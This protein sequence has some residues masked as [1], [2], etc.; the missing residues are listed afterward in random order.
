[1]NRYIKGRNPII[2]HLLTDRFYKA[3]GNF[4]EKLDRE[5]GEFYGGNFLGIRQRLEES[6]FTDLG[7]DAIWISAPYQQIMGWVPGNNGISR[8]YAYHGYWPLDFT[9][10]EPRFGTEDE[11]HQMVKAAHKIGIKV[12][13]DI[14]VGHCGYPDVESF[15]KYLPDAI[16]SELQAEQN[17]QIRSNNKFL[18]PCSEILAKWW[19]P[20]WIRS[21]LTGHIPGGEDDMTVCYHGLPR[22][23]LDNHQSVHLPHFLISKT[24][25]R[26][27]HLPDTNVLGYLVNWLTRWV[28]EHGID[29]FRCDSAK[30]VPLSVWTELR[31][32]ASCALKTWRS[33]QKDD[34]NISPFWMLG[35]VYGYGPNRKAQQTQVF[36]SLINFDFQAHVEEILTVFHKN[37]SYLRSLA[38]LRLDE[39]YMQYAKFCDSS[40]CGII[41]YLSSHDTHLFERTHLK[42]AASLLMLVPGGIA[43]YYGDEIGRQ[44]ISELPDDEQQAARSAMDWNSVDDQLLSHWKILGNFRKRHPSIEAG[45]HLCLSEDPYV[46]SRKVELDDRTDKIVVSIGTTGHVK[47]PVSDVFNDEEILYDAYSGRHVKVSNG[48][49]ELVAGDLVLLESAAH[50][51]FRGSL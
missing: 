51:N 47:I 1:M 19:G 15:Q 16:I 33:S 37:D 25:T 41:S 13:I 6:W 42:T 17:P 43:I 44:P 23:R 48:T 24:D 27:C 3:G 35:E 30:H 38:L 29:G 8:Q 7:V 4:N 28:S 10:T 36:D 26:A 18:K 5:F 9:V 11:F 45:E 46:F 2:Y 31:Q 14:V 34:E 20:S 40:Q 32:A 50:L 21:S 22:L 49:V 39:L 12:F